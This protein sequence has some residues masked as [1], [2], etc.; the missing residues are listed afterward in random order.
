MYEQLSRIQITSYEHDAG[1]TAS[2]CTR[3]QGVREG[4]LQAVGEVLLRR[5]VTVGYFAQGLDPQ[6]IA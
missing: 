4:V 1:R 3:R 2:S 5:T 6:R